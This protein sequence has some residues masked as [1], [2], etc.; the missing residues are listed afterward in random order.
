M[1]KN[2]ILQY[3]QAENYV[4]NS[5]LVEH[6]P[7]SGLQVEIIYKQSSV[8]SFLFTQQNKA[9]QQE[10]SFFLLLSRKEAHYQA[11]F[12]DYS[13]LVRF[14]LKMISWY[15]TIKVQA[16]LARNRLFILD[17]TLWKLSG[18]SCKK[19]SKAQPAAVG[20]RSCA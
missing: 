18:G 17:Q 13:S 3:F 10:A 15:M 6:N 19:S 7:F 20:W 4:I 1:E 12:L 16:F 9:C 11:L 14:L 5:I 2:Y 8:T